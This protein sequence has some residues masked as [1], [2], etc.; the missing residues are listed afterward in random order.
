MTGP[1][2]ASGR[3]PLLDRLCRLMAL[4]G[5]LVLV[6]LALLTATSVLGRYFLGRPI[7]GD[8]EL[9]AVLTAVAVSLFMPYCQLQKGHV[10]VDVFTERAPPAVR[11][12]LDALGSLAVALVALVLAWRLA[13]GGLELRAAGD[14]TMMLR[15]PTWWGFLVV[16][17][18]F[19]LMA[20]AGLAS[21]RRELRRGRMG[22]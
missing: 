11:A 20:V 12:A 1:V 2:P 18:G 4:L 3:G 8:I 5:G 16:V 6:A 9:V 10:I 7:T 22:P 13:L 19:A 14:E 17:P 15:L 21:F